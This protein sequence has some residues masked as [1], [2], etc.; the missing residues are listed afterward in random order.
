MKVRV[1][2]NRYKEAL[3]E[4]GYRF[5]RPRRAV[6][7]VL[8]EAAYPLSAAEVLAQLQ[9][10]Q[11]SVDLATVYRNLAVLLRV[12][13]VNQLGFTSDSRARYEWCEGRKVSHHVRCQACGTLASLSLR[14]LK[15]VRCLIESQTKFLIYEQSLEI[16]GLCPHC[17]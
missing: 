5:T 8:R 10:R 12:G 11:V 14:S 3:R 15:Q 1:S 6:L 13:L 7:Q 2:P 17:R 16:D 9:D 4:A